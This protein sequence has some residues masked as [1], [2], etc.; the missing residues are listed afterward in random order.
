MFAMKPC[1]SGS[2]VGS[3][4]TTRWP[5]PQMFSGADLL[6]QLQCNTGPLGLR[7]RNPSNAGPSVRRKCIL[8]RVYKVNYDLYCSLH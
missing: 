1:M 3:V 5:S 6:P 7:D 8:A 2:G 4:S